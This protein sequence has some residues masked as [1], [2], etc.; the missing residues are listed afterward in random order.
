MD[1]IFSYC[2]N[3]WTISEHLKHKLDSKYTSCC[4]ANCN[5]FRAKK[6]HLI[7]VKILL[8]GDFLQNRVLGAQ[9][10]S[11]ARMRN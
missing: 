8:R 10:Q 7:D 11:D 1:P 2:H 3:S 4:L 9:N 6:G 5:M